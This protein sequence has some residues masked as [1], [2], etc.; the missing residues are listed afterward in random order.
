[1][2]DFIS[3]FIRHM[4][5]QE[6]ERKMLRKWRNYANHHKKRRIRKKYRK[7]INEYFKKEFEKRVPH[8][9]PYGSN[10]YCLKFDRS[11][12]FPKIQ[13][14][15]RSSSGYSTERMTGGRGDKP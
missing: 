6:E 4:R 12:F 10:A 15:G 8:G 7:R 2:T 14:I 3:K 1:M 9:W 13:G 11:H 5:E